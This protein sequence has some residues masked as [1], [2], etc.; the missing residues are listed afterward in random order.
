MKDI[1]TVGEFVATVIFHKEVKVE[2]PV[3]VVA[4]NVAPVKEEVAP[5]EE[6]PVAEAE[7]PVA[8]AEAPVAE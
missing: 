1:K 3:I 4:E 5:V 6:A 8:E 2:L 7:A